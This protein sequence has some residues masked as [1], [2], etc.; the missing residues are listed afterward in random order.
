MTNVIA[1]FDG[2]EGALCYRIN[3]L[4]RHEYVRRFFALISKAGDGGF[5]V[6]MACVPLLIDGANALPVIARMAVATVVGIVLYK[7][8]KTR[9]VRERPFINH[10]DIHCGT[11]PLDRYSFPSGHTLHAASFAIMFTW[12]LPMLGWVTIPFAILVASSRVILGLH[13]PSD[14]LA[15]ALIG[16]MLAIIAIVL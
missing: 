11:A 2:L 12:Y 7:A 4:S 13:Y 8:L 3:R 9:L 10:G 5:W 1:Y 16:S 14:V 6:A 15:G